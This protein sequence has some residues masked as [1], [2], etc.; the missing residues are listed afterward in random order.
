MI[1]DGTQVRE[2]L[3]AMSNVNAGLVMLLGVS[4]GAVSFTHALVL[5]PMLI[6]FAV[7][8]YLSFALRRAAGRIQ[9]SNMIAIPNKRAAESDGSPQQL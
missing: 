3:L 8:F 1:K 4:V 9:S 5:V 2:M 7:L 6:V